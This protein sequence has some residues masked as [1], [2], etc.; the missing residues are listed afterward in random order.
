MNS[1]TK[2]IIAAVT[3]AAAGITALS[4]CNSAGGSPSQ[5]ADTAAS[6]TDTAQA[7]AEQSGD[8]AQTGAAPLSNPVAM[9]AD[10]DVDMTVALAY[11]TD[12][13]ALIKQL[14]AKTTAADHPVSE[15]TNPKTL[16]LYHWLQSVYGKQV[17]SAQQ[18]GNTYDKDSI[19]YYYY[20]DDLPAM[21]GFDFIF[22]TTP[23]G[24]TEDWTQMAI[25]WHTKSGGLVTFCWHWNVPIDVDEPDGGH[26]FYS[27]QIK[28]FK[29]ANA[30]T[31][32]TK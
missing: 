14:D 26:A 7:A 28:N 12:F 20:T 11:E 19:A 27:E 1:L 5:S 23:G 24:D 15:N 29:L 17:I 21:K 6:V 3:A 13:D 10:G 25:D 32:G 9:T 31:P 8:T 30:V 4:G 22:K 18:L 2:K 16:E